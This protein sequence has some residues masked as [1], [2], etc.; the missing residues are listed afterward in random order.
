MAV[1]DES[2]CSGLNPARSS[3][4]ATWNDGPGYCLLAC[5]WTVTDEKY[6]SCGC[7]YSWLFVLHQLFVCTCCQFCS[8]TD[9]G[10]DVAFAGCLTVDIWM[11]FC[12]WM[13]FLFCFASWMAHYQND[14][15]AF[16]YMCA[17]IIYFYDILHL[18]IYIEVENIR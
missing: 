11:V 10:K 3:P 18:I 2:Y 13:I 17:K 8:L 5:Q 14:E 1:T 16:Q 4:Q 15:M 12:F 6:S 7:L 9:I